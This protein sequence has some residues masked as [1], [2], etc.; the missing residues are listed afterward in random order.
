VSA[1]RSPS[2]AAWG[3]LPLVFEANRG[4]IDGP[5]VAF[6]RRGPVT[7]FFTPEG[8]V[9]D[10]AERHEDGTKSGVA[11]RLSFEGA[12]PVAP[13]TLEPRPTTVN[14]F[15]GDSPAEWIT[16][17]PTYARLR[18]EGLY[19]GVD[20]EVQDGGG[21][22]EYHLMLSPGARLADVVVRVDGADALLIEDGVL[23]AKTKKGDLRQHVPATW[24]VLPGGGRETLHAEF[25]IVDRERFGF[26]VEGW[27]DDAELVVDPVLVFASY[28]GGA[29]LDEC[30]GAAVGDDGSLF[31]TGRTSSSDFPRTAG[32]YDN[33]KSGSYEAY[34]TKFA[35]DGAS[36]VFSTYLGSNGSDLGEEIVVDDQNRPIVSGWLG[37]SGYPSV[38]GSYDTTYNGYSDTFVTKLAAT[39]NSLVFST[40]Y[41]GSNEDRPNGLALAPDGGVFIVGQTMSSNLP[42]TAGAQDTTH[43]G[44]WDAYVA[45]LNAAGTALVFSTYLG[46]NLTD[47]AFGV[48]AAP[49]GAAVVVGG[50]MSSTF[51]TVAGGFDTTHNGGFDGYVAKFNPTGGTLAWTTFLGGPWSDQAVAVDVDDLG[52]AY[53]TGSCGLGFPTTAGA[54]D[55]ANDGGEAFVA[56]V[57]ADGASLIYSTLLG[58]SSTDS[59]SAIKVDPLGAAHV[60]GYT[61]GAN[62][63]LTTI[64]YDTTFSGG[65]PAEGFLTKVGHDGDQLLFSTFVG[66]AANDEVRALALDSASATYVVGISLGDLGLAPGGYDATANGSDEGFVAKFDL[67]PAAVASQ[68]LNGCNWNAEPPTASCDA[69]V[70][71]QTAYAT[72]TAAPP[73]QLGLL[74][75]GAVPN[76]NSFLGFGC[77]LQMSTVVIDELAPLYSQTDGTWTSATAVAP[78][79]DNAGAVVRLQAL[80]LSASHPLGFVL[81]NGIEATLGY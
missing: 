7:T 6:T 37:G 26:S 33:V 67:A 38:A 24:Q 60:A 78:I 54:F 71:G 56:K 45:K 19:P 34:V 18:Y 50:A 47:W 51:P 25:R 9:V 42:T 40:F 62:F 21:A 69:P 3:R 35:P 61:N 52:R 11:L 13:K 77:V 57:A 79:A 81:S 41:G 27:R 63:P 2:A 70:L 30:H 80:F 58:S 75:I 10:A 65:S 5:A 43:N 20:V 22:P 72:G 59:G 53:V 29:G 46:G 28:L 15:R 31:V 39:G 66:S 49:D 16:D 55:V 23:V 14:Y 64:T 32:C 1:D 74:L 36:L 17:V 4:Q 8:F 44:G 76:N 12:D 73:N 68:L 48:A